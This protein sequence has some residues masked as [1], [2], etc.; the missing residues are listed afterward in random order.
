MTKVH[1]I[2]LVSLLIGFCLIMFLASCVD[3]TVENL[4]QTVDYQSMVKFVNQ[5]PNQT[6]TITMD[7]ASVGSLASGDSTAYMEAP[8]GSRSIVATYPDTTMTRSIF[9]DTEYKVRVSIQ[10]DSTGA[11]S[12]VKTVVGYVWQ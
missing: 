8:S 11:K 4:P 6:A 7:G 1:K 10:E 12:F 3:T 9:L 2:K 5:V